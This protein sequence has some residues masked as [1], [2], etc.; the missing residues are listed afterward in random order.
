MRN[1]GPEPLWSLRLLLLECTDIKLLIVH[2]NNVGKARIR[3]RGP[4]SSSSLPFLAP[5]WGRY[6]TCWKAATGK[7]RSAELQLEKWQGMIIAVQERINTSAQ[8][9][10]HISGKVFSYR[11]E[12]TSI[13]SATWF[14][15]KR[16]WRNK[17]KKKRKIKAQRI[18]YQILY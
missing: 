6:Q 16:C 10:T 18:L 11:Q 5:F 14:I 2:L 4:P 9:K 13:F 15:E 1:Q 7:C 12:S 3:P 17:E 8:C